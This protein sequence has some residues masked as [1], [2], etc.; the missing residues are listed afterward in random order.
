MTLSSPIAGSVALERKASLNS[1]FVWNYI[2]SSAVAALLVA[3]VLSFVNFEAISHLDFTVVY[4][5]RWALVRATGFTLT[6]T[7][8]AMTVGLVVGIIFAI[9]SLQGFWPI[10]ALVTAYVEIWRNT[11]L[12]VQLFWVHFALPLVTG[13]S[14][15]A[16]ESGLIAITMQSSAYL[17]DV[18]RTG[19]QAVHKGQYEAAAA[20]GLPSWSKWIDVILPQA[21]KV[22]IPP[23]ASIA[24]TFFK[25]SAILS[26]LSVGELMTQTKNI[27]TYSQRPIE[28]MTAAGVIYWFLGYT[29]ASA[30]YKLERLLGSDQRER[31]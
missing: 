10:R 18:A 21:L 2:V 24:I 26:L 17:T 5:Y 25:A 30:T 12:V 3:A 23:L 6:I 29:F 11:P 16:V 7:L 19:I 9:L 15:T 31:P 13:Y 1:R 27:A 28:V 20:L 14:T 8:I 22:V 4:T